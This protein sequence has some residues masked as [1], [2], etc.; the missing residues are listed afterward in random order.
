MILFENKKYDCLNENFDL[1]TGLMDFKNEH[2]GGFFTKLPISEYSYRKNHPTKAK[3]YYEK[4]PFYH[5]FKIVD[6]Y[7]KASNLL[8]S[9][10]DVSKEFIS[11]QLT[12]ASVVGLY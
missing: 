3:I 5:H 12:K 11:E 9:E 2:G 10:N 1:S 8:I 6:D 4:N 7:G